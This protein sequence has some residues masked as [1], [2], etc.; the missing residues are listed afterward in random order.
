MRPQFLESTKAVVLLQRM[1]GQNA[2]SS[3][4]ARWRI[5]KGSIQISEVKLK[6]K[7]LA[8]RLAGEQGLPLAIAMLLEGIYQMIQLRQS[9][10]T[11]HQMVQRALNIYGSATLVMP[12]ADEVAKVLG[13]VHDKKRDG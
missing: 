10:G 5:V 12:T 11:I 8:D 4:L 3:F 7:L 9:R 6:Q 13:D 1:L 2:Q